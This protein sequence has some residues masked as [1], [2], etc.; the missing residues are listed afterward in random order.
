MNPR[1]R[2]AFPASI[3][4]VVTALA[5]VLSGSAAFTTASSAADLGAGSVVWRFDLDPAARGSVD[6]DLAQVVPAASALVQSLA[7]AVSFDNHVSRCRGA[8]SSCSYAHHGVDGRWGIHLDA[9]TTSATFPSNRFL[10]YHEIGHA[11]WRL[12][13]DEAHRRGF[14]DA[15]HA[16]LHGRPC[17]DEI[18]RPCAV[19]EEVFADEFARYVGG[20]A[21]S[22]SFYWTPPLLDAATFGAL[23]RVGTMG[24]T[25]SE[26]LW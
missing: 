25:P 19:L 3:A 20:F 9:Q 26:V 7:G 21:A 6:N 10:V 8:A 24:S 15:V 12:V 13:L 18:G 17:T 16:A 23:V 5:L 11:A 14:A 1:S 22:M 4:A 2:K